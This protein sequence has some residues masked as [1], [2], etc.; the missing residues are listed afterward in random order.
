METIT[1]KNTV[2]DK[3]IS[4]FESLK[5]SLFG[6]L[7]IREQAIEAFTKQGIPNRK[8][9][10]YKYLNVDLILKGEFAF[11]NVQTPSKA[12]IEHAEFLK[13]TIVA[14]VE[15][16]AFVETFSKTQN[17]PKG[18]AICS[19]AKASI[20]QK[21]IFDKHYSRYA[22]VNADAFIALN[23]ALANDGVFIH[24]AKGAVI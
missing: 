10:E 4:E 22:D 15:N 23:T 18:L 6:N 13:D 24:I 17:L 19:L 21:Q 5:K 2:I 14:V 3:F 1:K 11:T 12:Q 9:E 20:D 16:G 8:N 7:T